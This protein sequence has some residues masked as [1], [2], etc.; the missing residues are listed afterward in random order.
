MDRIDIHVEVDGVTYDELADK[1]NLEEKSADIRKRVNRARARQI[2]RFKGTKTTCNAKMTSQ[3]VN[4]FCVL[5]E[6]CQELIKEAF[7]SFNLSARAHNRILKVART[8]ADLDDS[9]DIELYHLAEA[10]GY[11]ALDKKYWV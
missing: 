9:D 5:N 2:E 7:Q 3:Q 11:R 1:S 10:I 4:E 6:E 8:M